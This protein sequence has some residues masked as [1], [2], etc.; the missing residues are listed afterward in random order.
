MR[1]TR[2]ELAQPIGFPVPGW[3]LPPA[4]PREYGFPGWYVERLESFRTLEA[5]FVPGTRACLLATGLRDGWRCLEVGAG[6]GSIARWVSRRP[7]RAA[8]RL[9][10]RAPGDRG[11]VQPAGGPTERRGQEQRVASFQ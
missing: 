5:V 3:S 7:R 6:A 9:R 1:P 10:Q 8:A 11:H 4:P 2:N